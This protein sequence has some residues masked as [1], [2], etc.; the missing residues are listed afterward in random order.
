MLH[1]FENFELDTDAF[2]LRRDGVICRLEPQ[3]FD[4]LRYLVE[5]PNR[6]ISRDEVFAAIWAG[7][8]VS[9]TALSSRI[10]AARRAI[11]DNGRDQRLIQTVHGRGFRFVLPTGGGDAAAVHDA[12]PG[13]ARTPPLFGRTRELAMLQGCLRD[14]GGAQGRLAFLAGESGIGKTSIVR[15]FM[16]RTMAAGCR[17]VRIGHCV[18]QSGPAE[19]YLPMLDALGQ[20]CRSEAAAVEILRRTAPSWLL[21]LPA[22]LDDAAVAALHR[23]IVGASKDR[24]LREMSD[25]LHEL[26]AAAP[27]VLVFEDLHWSDVSTLELLKSLARRGLP[28]GLLII[29]TYTTALPGAQA[30]PVDA[31]ARALEARGTGTLIEVAGLDRDAVEAFL[32]R[33]LGLSALPDG[34][35]DRLQAR[36]GGN[37]FFMGVLVDWWE[38][39]GILF[40]APGP[41]VEIGAPNGDMEQIPPQLQHILGAEFTHLDPE[42]QAILEWAAVAGRSFLATTV[43][44]AT[45]SAADGVRDRLFD[46]ARGGRFIS[47]GPADDGTWEAD[48]FRFTHSLNRDAIYWGIS[49]ARRRNMHAALGAARLAELGP[50][51]R[52]RPA[53]L[54]GHFLL[55]GN[56]MDAIPWLLAAARQATW[57][58]GHG[59]ALAS[60]QRARVLLPDIADAARR[61]KWEL[62]IESAVASNVLETAG[63]AAAEA[64]EAFL[65]AVALAERAGDASALSS[66][67]YHLAHIYELRGEFGKTQS[68]MRRRRTL[69]DSVDVTAIVETAEL[70]AC[71]AFHQGN[72]SAAVDEAESGLSRYDSRR[73]LHLLAASETNVAVSC[74]AWAARAQCFMGLPDTALG[75]IERAL[76]VAREEAPYT[77]CSAHG[78]A[79]FLRQHRNE[80]AQTL[81]HADKVIELGTARNLPYRVATGRILRGWA[82]SVERGD[83]ALLDEMEGALE[84]C[85]R[86]GVRLEIPFFYGLIADA[87]LSAGDAAKALL[88]LSKAR[89]SPV[90]G[91][92]YYYEAELHRLWGCALARSGEREEAAG[93]FERALAVAAEQSARLLTLR[94]ALSMVAFLGDD[95]VARTRIAS[96]YD[97]ITEGFDMPDLRKA[98][99]ILQD[100][101]AG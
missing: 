88:T 13:A 47:P 26:A 8:I 40:D 97:A 28:G 70:M 3:V 14:A 73:H 15:H 92:G 34:L 20:L 39:R 19:P 60:L 32:R 58:G 63:V 69:R 93:A 7:R 53:E 50:R 52:E 27:L 59:E 74:E 85:D 79:A 45:G 81:A 99:A 4:L 36:S 76:A 83:A 35:A 16:E 25:A 46:L 62:E 80:P 22:L 6:L 91:R 21:Q 57:R 37:P 33:R 49:A 68:L 17:R 43:A 10:K 12:L 18:E 51:A 98:A 23:R 5:N 44:S 78:Q 67:L 41:G 38:S 65:N 100:D 84:D 96:V 48:S 82:I 2:E 29:G 61:L 101:R 94:T 71:S 86:L 30:S 9:D 24:M 54:A 87:W 77:L 31:L 55:G 89:C 1:R 42:D 95:A 75:R 90:G 11:G 66:L 56:A 64:E 72:L